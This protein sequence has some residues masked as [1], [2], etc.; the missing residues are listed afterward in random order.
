MQFLLPEEL[1][2]LKNINFNSWEGF[3]SITENVLNN[4]IQDETNIANTTK[5][6]LSFILLINSEKHFLF[7]NWILHDECL[8]SAVRKANFSKLPERLNF[9]KKHALWKEFKLFLRPFIADSIKEMTQRA[10]TNETFDIVEEAFG[11]IVFLHSHEVDKV[12]SQ[13]KKFFD[14]IPLGEWRAN[15]MAKFSAFVSV[16]RHVGEEG[17]VITV[18]L[19]DFIKSSGPFLSDIEIIMAYEILDLLPLNDAHRFEVRQFKEITVKRIFTEDNEIQKRYYFINVAI[20][21]MALSIWW[22]FF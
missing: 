17:Y 8:L 1:N 11:Y 10:L 13:I 15:N 6:E 16:W 21:L 12:E 22:L 5:G 7:Y 19:L 9:Y 4:N 2:L 3:S 18:H 20:I 14:N